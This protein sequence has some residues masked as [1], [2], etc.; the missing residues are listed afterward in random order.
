MPGR[1]S[2][3]SRVLR[4]SFEGETSL[5]A[6]EAL[7]DHALSNPLCPPKPLI[8]S[9]VRRSTSVR[10]L[11]GSGVRKG[12]RLFAERHERLGGKFAIVTQP[13]VQ[14][15]V[16]RMASVYSEDAGLELRV[17]ETEEPALEWLLAG[18]DVAPV[19]VRDAALPAS[20]REAALH[21]R[22]PSNV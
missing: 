9:D 3:Q 19:S 11:A 5:D 7:L 13:G 16:M 14:Y 1:Y 4:L 12:V 2:F 17:F 8:L 6:L 10:G 20:S 18:C 22:H 21:A 15:G